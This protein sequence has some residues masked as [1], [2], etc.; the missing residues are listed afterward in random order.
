[1]STAPGAP[2]DPDETVGAAL[3]R[4]RHDRRLTGAELAETVGMSQ[5]K[6]SR[7]ERG[8]GAPDPEDVGKL[9]RAL[10]AD[11]GQAQALMERAEQSHNTMTDWRPTSVGLAGRQE[12]MK[13]WEAAAE[14]VRDFQPALLTGLLQT[15]GYA[16]ASLL[17][18]QRLAQLNTEA[19]AE[20]AVLAAVTARI[21]RQEILADRSKSFRFVITEAV[22]RNQICPPAEMLAQI[23]HLREI[24][25]RHANVVIGI[26]P[27]GTA[28]DIPPLHGFVLLDDKLIV[29]DA[30]NTG[31]TSRGRADVETYLRVFDEFEHHATT[32]IEPILDTYQAR[33]LERLRP[34]A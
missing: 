27:D 31:L 9:A 32:A 7:I 18:F 28:V 14:V 29:I 22:L 16:R 10:G 30:Y 6:I 13:D 34:P 24:S 5:P 26:I 17:S 11:E 19:L 23:G 12:R 4:M 21:R 20:T 1:V 33:Y 15:S 8:K 2:A 3:S 25:A